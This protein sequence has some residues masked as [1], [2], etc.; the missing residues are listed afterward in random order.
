[1]MAVVLVMRNR[2]ALNVLL[3]PCMALSSVLLTSCTDHETR[4]EITARGFAKTADECLLDVRDRQLRYENS[5]NCNALGTLSTQFIEAGGFDKNTPDRITLIAEKGRAVA[6]MARAT[7][8]A[9]NRRLSL[10]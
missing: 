2:L 6:W 7:S 10:W 1:M 9:G 8:L 3:A 5:P 4:L